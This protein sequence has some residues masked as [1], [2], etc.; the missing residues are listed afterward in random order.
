MDVRRFRPRTEGEPEDEA[1]LRRALALASGLPVVATCVGGV[2]ELVAH[3]VT[4][5]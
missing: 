3:G 1:G 2:P 4:G 5:S